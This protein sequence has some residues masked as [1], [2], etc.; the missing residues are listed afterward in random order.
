MSSEIAFCG[1][2]LVVKSDDW[3]ICL[4]I[5]TSSVTLCLK[6]ADVQ[7]IVCDILMF[8]CNLVYIA[9]LLNKIIHS[10]ANQIA[11]LF[12][13]LISGRAPPVHLF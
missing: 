6:Q 8:F 7:I 3:M 10:L 12:L 2:L 4:D 9:Q 1:Y 13:K 11:C 5:H